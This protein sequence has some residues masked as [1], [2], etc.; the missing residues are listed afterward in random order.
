MLAMPSSDLIRRGV[1]RRPVPLLVF[2]MASYGAGGLALALV[3]LALGY[4]P[5][6]ERDSAAK[7]VGDA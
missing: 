4:A 6:S 7:P 3:W 1:A 2:L 5:L